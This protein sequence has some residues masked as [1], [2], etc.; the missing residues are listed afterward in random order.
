MG[1]IWPGE[2]CP[3]DGPCSL[4]LL[5]CPVVVAPL[6]AVLLYLLLEMDVLFCDISTPS[7][8]NFSCLSPKVNILLFDAVLFVALESGDLPPAVASLSAMSLSIIVI[9]GV[10]GST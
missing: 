10:C 7:L 9:I 5:D 6:S 8:H 1:I 2:R 4:G 3:L